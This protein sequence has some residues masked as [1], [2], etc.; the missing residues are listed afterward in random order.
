M[1]KEIVKN[2][3][4]AGKEPVDV[5]LTELTW[6]DEEDLTMQVKEKKIN[7]KTATEEVVYNLVRLQRLKLIRGITSHKVSE[8][9][10]L[11]TPRKDVLRLARAFSKL[12]DVGDAEKSGPSE[13]G[14]EGEPAGGDE[15]EQ[16]P[17]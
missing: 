8:D 9:E 15:K 7:A 4:L 10:L 1:E 3:R 13:V 17:E 16:S 12:N 14:L 11:S 2:I 5:E 6:G